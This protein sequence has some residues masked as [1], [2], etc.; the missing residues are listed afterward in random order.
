[1]KLTENGFKSIDVNTIVNTNNNQ[2]FICLKHDVETAP[3][4]SSKKLTKI[5]NK[6]GHKVLI[7]FKHIYL[8]IKKILISYVKFKRARSRKF[9]II[10]M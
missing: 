4:K 9:L 7:M 3:K 1:M 2:N 5:E 10:T 6:Y 8:K